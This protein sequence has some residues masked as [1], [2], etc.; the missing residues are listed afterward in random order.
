M[1]D[2]GDV[3]FDESLNLEKK[4]LEKKGLRLLEVLFQHFLVWK[5]WSFQLNLFYLEISQAKKKMS[6]F[7]RFKKSL[8]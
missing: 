4:K 3:W 8:K 1:G 6:I 2:A 5:I 7:C